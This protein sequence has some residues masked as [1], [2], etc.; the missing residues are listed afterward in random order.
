MH[1]KQTA[2]LFAVALIFQALV[3]SG[4]RE[5]KKPGK[6]SGKVTYAGETVPVGAITFIPKEGQAVIVE[7][8]DGRYTAD[9]VPPG[10]ATVTVRTAA[11]REQFK[12][13]EQEQQRLRQGIS[14]IPVR[15][16]N[17]TVED[18]ERLKQAEERKKIEEKL[19]AKLKDMI[20][21]PGKYVDPEKSGLAVT[22][23]PGAQ[24]INLDLPRVGAEKAK[25][26]ED[27][28][29]RPDRFQVRRRRAGP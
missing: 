20:D 15:R 18:R 27:R 29:T 13:M 6:I 11:Y 17:L 24:E 4:G 10:P 5:D 8:E 28:Q 14:G 3:C 16:E 23:R 12:A 9:K 2:G 25:D 22:I 7:I 19:W 26:A 21:V 1:R